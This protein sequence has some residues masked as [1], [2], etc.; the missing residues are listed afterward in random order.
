MLNPGR[1]IRKTLEEPLRHFK[2][3][4]RALWRQRVEEVAAAVGLAPRLLD[5]WPSMLS[6][7]EC[8]RAALVRAL[9]V[10]PR[11]ILA[12]EALAG[13]DPDAT[14][15]LLA[16]LRR[17]ARVRDLSLFLVTHDLDV[18]R[19]AAD[20]IMVLARGRL[21]GPFAVSEATPSQLRALWPLAESATPKDDGQVE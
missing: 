13:L 11:V 3:V 14:A 2:T 8:R 10:P 4:P 5:V 17:E 18:L 20:R 21:E 7:G 12:D 1:R 19:D 9:V 15:G 6:G 16:Y